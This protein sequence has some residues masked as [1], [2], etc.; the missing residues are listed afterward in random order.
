MISAI[1]ALPLLAF[2]ACDGAEET[3]KA[4]PPPPPQPKVVQDTCTGTYPAYWQ[5]PDPKFAGQWLDQT[6]SNTPDSQN[7]NPQNPAY[8]NP[9]FKLSDAFPRAAVSDAKD[10]PWR[11]DKFKA[12]FDPAT[13][14]ADKT[15]LGEEYSWLVMNYMEEGNTNSGNVNTDWSLCK[16]EVRPWYH[17]PFQ[18]Y[19][20]LSGRDF[21]HG[22]TREAPVTFSLKNVNNGSGGDT[23]N[24]VVWAV[25]FYNATAAFTLGQVWG[26]DGTA[27]LPK[28]NMK[29]DEGA[30]IGKLL[31]STATPDQF[32]NLANVPT[33][34][35]AVSGY[36][37]GKPTASPMCSPPSG[38]DMPAQSAACPRSLGQVHLMQFDFAVKDS[39]APLGWVYGTFVA[40]GVEKASEPDA[41]KRISP[42][43][44]MWGNDTPPAG[45][46]AFDTPADPRT[47]GFAEEVVFWD[48]VDRLNAA[49]GSVATQAPGHMGC[50]TRLNGPA[51]NINSS[52]LSCHMT[53]AVPDNNG[54]TPPLLAQFA[55]SSSPMTKQ[56]VNPATNKDA[57]GSAAKVVNN[58]SYQQMDG[59]YFADTMC[60]T[61][62]NMTVDGKNVL[63]GM[64]D[65]GDGSSTWIAT[66]FSMQAS[67]SMVQ[68]QQWQLHAAA[69]KAA[70]EGPETLGERAPRTFKLD[71]PNRGE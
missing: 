15:K 33:W 37:D 60:G 14:A 51:D 43:G 12:L 46:S 25:A 3:V 35:A 11:A 40:D 48:V 56:C 66:D 49:G 52:C 67:I 61:P 41:W 23:L 53:G 18:T 38:A 26:A 45:S 58:V 63:T 32:P 50:D 69:E 70:E 59:V 13:S 22:L 64:P 4:P 55:P 10:Q 24:T 34:T 36:Q 31:F 57:S 68:W 54:N 7:W 42:L 21:V 8:T 19:N 62:V 39:R 9:A 1:V 5:D 20:V 17:I 71:L 16:N 65:Y 28:S 27:T 29:F 2:L 30:V 47:N 6:V 44:I